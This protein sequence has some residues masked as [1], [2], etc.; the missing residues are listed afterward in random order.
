[1]R[2]QTAHRQ[3]RDSGQGA[4][5][6]THRRTPSAKR[7]LETP[8][9]VR[10]RS[11]TTPLIA[12]IAPLDP[13]DCRGPRIALTQRVR[14]RPRNR[15]RVGRQRAGPN[16]RGQGTIPGQERAR[17]AKHLHGYRAPRLDAAPAV[18]VRA[19]VDL[20]D[21]RQCVLHSLHPPILRLGSRPTRC[22][23]RHRTSPP[24]VWLGPYPRPS[25]TPTHGGPL[26]LLDGR[27]IGRLVVFQ[28]ESF[29]KEIC[30]FEKF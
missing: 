29:N 17:A 18:E 12:K 24:V 8:Y 13:K 6:S 30:V 28:A 4:T 2:N 15:G 11:S 21:H 26:R 25:G 27:A 1:M 20:Q 23:Q 14:I 19:A 10:G 16:S 3:R 5:G 9:S 22:R 7:C